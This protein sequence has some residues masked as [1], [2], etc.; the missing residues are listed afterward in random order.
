MTLSPDTGGVFD[1]LLGLVRHGL[2]GAAGDGRQFI[3]WVHHED[4]LRAVRWLIERDDVDGVV[5]IASPN[6]VA[7]GEFMRALRQAAGVSVGLP[8]N[9]VM[10]EIGA[11]LLRTETELILKSRRVI[12]ARMMEHGFAFR[13]PRWEDAAADLIREW[14]DV[15]ARRSAAA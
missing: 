6:P 13:F 4:F 7:N 2:G 14:R 8:A 10:L 15:R 3:S 9:R 1:T 11:V 12:P 5:N